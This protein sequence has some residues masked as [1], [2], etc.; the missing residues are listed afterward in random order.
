MG[1]E[2]LRF[3]KKKKALLDQPIHNCRFPSFPFRIKFL[4]KEEKEGKEE[5]GDTSSP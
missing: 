5:K 3:K 4:G 2:V 1:R